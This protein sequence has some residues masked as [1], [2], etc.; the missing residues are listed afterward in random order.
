MIKER[1][2]VD[3]IYKTM[4]NE[5]VRAIHEWNEQNTFNTGETYASNLYEALMQ[6]IFLNAPQHIEEFWHKVAMNYYIPED[7]VK[8][9]R[10]PCNDENNLSKI[11]VEFP[12]GKT[13]LPCIEE[14]HHKYE[15]D[16][17]ELLSRLEIFKE[18]DSGYGAICPIC[19]QRTLM[20]QKEVHSACCLG[21]G[22][23][24]NSRKVSVNGI[25]AIE[26][27]CHTSYLLKKMT[28]IK[29]CF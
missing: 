29:E 23:Q 19:G 28:P 14:L 13:Y 3:A 20:I 25:V 2:T 11:W 6:T 21:N 10:N 26:N 15:I 1:L 27:R 7:D 18:V 22:C 24:M 8:Y 17:E 12:Y 16:K 5:Y 4:D 9:Y